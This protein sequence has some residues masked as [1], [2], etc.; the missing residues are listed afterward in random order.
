[1]TPEDAELLDN[2]PE[3][4]REANEVPS[5]ERAR[6]RELAAARVTEAFGRDLPH[7]RLRVSPLGA[8]WS[9]DL[10]LYVKTPVTKEGLEALGWLP[11]ERLSRKGDPNARWAVMAEGKVLTGLDV[12]VGDQPQRNELETIMNRCRRRGR[13]GLREVLELRVLQRGGRSLS[14]S[15]SIL[16]AAA[17]AEAALDGAELA[18]WLD[19]PAEMPPIELVQGLPARLK[20]Q[21]ARLKRKPKIVAV[22]GVDGSGKSTL[23]DALATELRAAGFEVHRVWARPGMEMRFVKV[24]A[25]SLKRLLRM[26]S[27]TGVRKVA[28]GEATAE[29]RPSSRRGLV[30]WAWALMVTLSYIAKVRGAVH[31][32]RGVVV[33]DRHLL[34]ALVTLDFV[35]E[36]VNLR[37]QRALIKSLIPKAMTTFYLAIEADQAVARKQSVVFGEYAVKKQ[38][39]HYER[40]RP[41]FE[42]VVELDATKP[43]EELTAEAL[44]RVASRN[45]RSKPVGWES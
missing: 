1:M 20:A 40:R 22:S 14:G 42:E 39:E 12:H 34:D 19:G 44:R 31:G 23:A 13:V 21:A 26:G 5:A 28:R 10:D 45:D 24:L 18:R 25:R 16:A 37:L 30:G 8:E 4:K 9:K 43:A 32:R 7:G 6:A 38:L 2:L 27:G 35:Y 15:E 36:G 41:D 33:F 11:L 17:R 3:T 29:T